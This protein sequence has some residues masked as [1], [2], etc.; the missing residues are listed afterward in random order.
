LHGWSLEEIP[1]TPDLKLLAFTRQ[2]APRS[3]LPRVYVSAG[4]HG[5]EPAG[6]LAVRQ[7][8]SD[9]AWP[10]DVD[11]WICP[12]LNPGGF[13]LNRRENPAG[14][15]LNRQY[16]Q[17][18]APETIAH[19]AWLKRQPDFDF[20]LCLHED[21]ESQGF[22]LFEANPDNGSSYAQAILDR[23][24]QVCPIDRSPTIEG[25]EAHD[26]IIRPNVNPA[27]RP[28]WPEALFLVANKARLSCTLEAP[29]DF[30]LAVRVAAL[31][32]GVNGAL[33]AIGKPSSFKPQ[34]PLNPQPSN[35]NAPKNTT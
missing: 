6:P 5:D 34:A 35:I 15:D 28:D 33:E 7:L 24:S 19:I 27:K 20:C 30:P 9:N 14:L 1:A 2:H 16:R 21:W 23:V 13:P 10:P 11:L 4:I 29:S 17:P 31:V 25:W 22:Y 26:G 32:A 3:A 12:C 18:V 8:L